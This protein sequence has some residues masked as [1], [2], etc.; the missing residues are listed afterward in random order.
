MK[1]RILSILLCIAVIIC[2]MPAT[3]LAAGPYSSVPLTLTVSSYSAPFINGSTGQHKV[4]TYK[5]T[6]YISRSEACGTD[7]NAEGSATARF[8]GSNDTGWT[9]FIDVVVGNYKAT[10][11][12]NAKI[13]NKDMSEATGSIT[14]GMSWNTQGEVGTTISISGGKDLPKPEP[15]PGSLKITKDIAGAL[16]ENST[17]LANKAF[18]FTITGPNNYRNTITLPTAN[19]AWSTTISGLAP[20][21]Y[22]V[23]EDEGAASIE[24]YNL[25]VTGAGN[26]GNYTVT[27]DGITS[28]TVTN[29]YTVITQPPVEPTSPTADGLKGILGDAF[30]TVDC[31]NSEINPEHA[32]KTY[33]LLD[34]GYEI[35]APTASDGTYTCTITLEPDKYVDH[36]NKDIGKEHTLVPADQTGTITLT[37]DKEKETW[38]AP[39]SLSVIF[40]V[41][42]KT[43]EEQGPVAPNDDELK[44]ILSGE[45]VT[46]KCINET[47]THELKEKTYG[48]LPSGYKVGAVTDVDG[49]YTCNVTFL[50]SAYQAQYN[51]DT[52][53]KHVL[54][55]VQQ[56]Q[57]NATITLTWNEDGGWSAP[58][59]NGVTFTVRCEEQQ[60]EQTYTV[61]YKDGCGGT[62]FK[63]DVHKD[64]VKDTA[65]PAF[66]GGTPTR[67]GYT[68]TGWDPKVAATVTSDAVY[69]ATWNKNETGGGG[70]VTYYTV[71]W[72][73]YDNTTLETDYCTY[74]QMPKYDGATPVKPADDKYTYEFIG[75]DKE[76]VK[77]TGN[78]V[79]TAQFKAVAKEPV[80]PVNP[81]EPTKP[82]KPEKPQK[83]AT[84]DASGNTDAEKSE[85]PKTA[86]ANDLMLWAALLLA[87]GTGLAGTALRKR[88]ADSGK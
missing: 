31:T 47:A 63:D 55:P 30:V 16:S 12:T 64:I 35:G 19:G 48:L 28:A 68:F 65:T 41:I 5:A 20:G 9:L 73:N 57:Y 43:P 38:T 29:N 81:T 76:V 49:K 14:F 69:T 23:T 74:G 34:G 87:A 40:K 71:K 15:Q 25:T 8:V 70:T 6:N 77:V 62:V 45:F 26:S 42:C 52:K 46:V 4:S 18:S 2:M 72:N 53:S 21:G 59:P 78:A 1:K 37:W 60:E 44:G 80:D 51:D 56:A 39:E 82:T 85:V 27:S 36:Y 83:P 22:N 79:Y 66:S 3:A 13:T 11:T 32:T 84:P 58:K 33:G 50:A 54:D 75:W 10:W 61:T 86:D 67:E 17:E 7:T 24:G 88:K